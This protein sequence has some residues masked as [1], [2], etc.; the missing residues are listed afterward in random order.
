MPK[1]TDIQSILIIGAGPIIIGQACEF[2]Y[3]GAQ[4]CKALREEG[5]KVILVNSNPATIMT[6]PGTADVTYIEPITWQVVERI[7]EKERPD[8][9]LPTMGGQTALNC[10]LDLGR[11]GVLA[12]YGVELIGASEEAIDKA[13]DRLKF[14]DAMTKIGLGSARSG[15][16]HSMEEALQVQGGIGFPVII[17][18]SFT[19]GGTGGGIAYNMEEFHEICKRGLEASPTNELLIEESLLGWKEYEME[20]VRDRADNCIIVCSIENLDPMGVHTGDSITVAPSQTLTDK[21]YQI[22]RN[23]SIAVLREIGV[24]TGG[25]NVQ[26]AINPKDGRMIVIEMNPRVSRSSA[27]ASKATGFPIAKV[28]AKLAVGYTLDE[29]K[30]DITGGATPASF[31][32][33]IDYVVTK[34]P[35]FAFEKF[36]QANDRLTTQMKSVGEVMAMG[37]TFQE[38]FQKALR[39]LEVGAYGLDEVETDREDLEHELVNPGAQRIWYVGQAFREGYTQ[40]QV[41]ALTKIDPWFL[42]QIEDIVLTEKALTGRSLKAIQA[43][44]LRALKQKG[45]SD[46]RLAKLLGTDE[47]AV[48]LHRHT[49]GVRPVFKRVDTCAAEFATS[50]AYMYS[51]YEEECEAHPTD[52]KKIMVLGGGPNRIGQGIEFDYC[53]VHAALALREDGYETIMVNCNPETVSTDYDTSDRLYFEPITLEDILEIVHIEK[54]VGVIVQFGGQTPLKR[55]RALEENGVPIIGTSPDMIDAAEDRERF[56]KLLTDLGLKQPPNRTARTP[57]EAVRLAAEIGYPLVVRPSYVLGGRAMEIVHEQKDLERYMR[58]AVKVSNESPVLLD[59]FLNDATEV[60]VD[61]LSDGQQVII[62]GIME[63]IEQAGVHSGD[64][65]CS[66]PPYT[67]SAALQDEL[68]RQTEAMARA[69]NVCGLMNVQFAIQGEGDNA[70]VYVLEVNPRASRTVPFVSKA[71]SLPLAKV[72]ARCMAGQSLASQGVTGEIVPPYYSV[73]EAVFPFVKFPGVDTILGPEMKSTGEV[74]GV[75]RSFAEAFVKSQIAAS[76]RLPET[77]LVFISVKPT[78]RPAAVEVARELHDLGFRLVATRGTAGAI[79]AAG[80]PVAV[81]NKVTEGRPHIVD[82]IKNEEICLV[83]NTVEEKRQAITDSRSI[84]TSALAAKVTVYTTIE[85]ARA[86]CMGMRHLAGLEVYSVQSLHAELKQA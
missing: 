40:E 50:T 20:V 53:C 15:I 81:V 57:E 77:G 38:S 49:L 55:A 35:R 31:E 78:D 86:A 41:F 29:L 45:F 30:N 51:S 83:I 22:L 54:P 39:G 24:D 74:M 79:E 69:L 68:R 9:I 2:D 26:F 19:L 12:K 70:V 14:K 5:Y 23:A 62:G 16:A 27:L 73:K 33:S 10:A 65:A 80:I 25:S 84:R 66:L 56:Q 3:S 1:R 43:A 47:T 63:H 11:N 52:K 76:V 75:G 4:A 67:L 6:D 71:C 60:D 13:E 8:A 34:I 28:A 42:A 37:R 85:G 58:E 32:P 59:R 36:P 64:S 44:E 17:R 82:M 46:R 48:R 7:I 61:A 21:E 72:A 18:P